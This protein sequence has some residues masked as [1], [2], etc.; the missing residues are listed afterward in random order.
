MWNTTGAFLNSWRIKIALESCF[1][2][3]AQDIWERNLRKTTLLNMYNPILMETILKV[4]REQFKED[5]QNTAEEIALSIPET[6]FECEQ[7]LKERGG[8]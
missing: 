2:K 4:L 3:H 7:I 5:D 1:E 6:S 8:F